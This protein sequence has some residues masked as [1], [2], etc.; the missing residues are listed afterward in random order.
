MYESKGTDIQQWVMVPTL[1]QVPHRTEPLAGAPR[2]AELFARKPPLQEFWL[3]HWTSIYRMMFL[4]EK[5]PQIEKVR[6]HQVRKARDPSTFDSNGRAET[7]HQAPFELA[8]GLAASGEAMYVGV[9]T[10]EVSK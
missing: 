1:H 4:A 5:H 7:F 3:E 2:E 9:T 10:N 8:I 6:K